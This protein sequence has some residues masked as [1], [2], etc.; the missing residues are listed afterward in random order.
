[1]T[2]GETIPVDQWRPPPALLEDRSEPGIVFD[3]LGSERAAFRMSSYTSLKHDAA[4]WELTP[5][6]FKTDR[7][8][9]IESDDLPGGSAAG[10][11]LHEV[12]ERLD[13]AQIANG[14]MNDMQGVWEH[15]QLKARNRWVD[16]DT[17]TGKIPALL[18]PAVPD[19]YMPR[20]DPVPS[21]GEH[22]PAILRELGYDEDSIARLRAQNAI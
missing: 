18:P 22:T 8:P 13:S 9:V 20:M 11:F 17:P 5:A 10:L 7:A 1:M 14:R 21:L 4:A 3:R 19:Q 2:K 12:I 16:I 15:H 6:D